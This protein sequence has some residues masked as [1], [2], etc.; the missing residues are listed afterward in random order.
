MVNHPAYLPDLAPSDYRLFRK[1][2]EYL[3]G[4]GFIDKNVINGV[5]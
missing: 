3:C 5:N 1:L 4:K 2:Q